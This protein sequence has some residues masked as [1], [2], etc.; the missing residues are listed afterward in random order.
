[1]NTFGQTNTAAAGGMRGWT[2]FLSYGLA[3]LAIGLLA[4]RR[5][6][7]FRGIFAMTPNETPH[8]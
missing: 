2:N 7:A 3:A 6:A 1:M 4:F 8:G 5:P